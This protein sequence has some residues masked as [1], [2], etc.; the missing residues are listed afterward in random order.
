MT[1]DWLQEAGDEAS[2]GK[3]RKQKDLINLTFTLK[4]AV[5]HHGKDPK[6]D[7]PTVSYIGTIRLDG[8][9]EDEEFW[10]GGVRVMGQVESILAKGMLPIRLRHGSIALTNGTAYNLE[11][12]GGND[13]PAVREPIGKAALIAYMQRNA[14][15][16]SDVL[17]A[18]GVDS[19][20]NPQQAWSDYIEKVIALDGVKDED[21]ACA[22][23]LK[24]LS[25]TTPKPQAEAADEIPFA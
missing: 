22:M 21:G 23:I 14:M 18:L 10:L 7:E 9:E 20:G 11:L 1:N 8:A 3:A 2:G 25:S 19:G 4:S 13:A 12:V 17:K 24:T 15:T 6:T 5:L 16:G